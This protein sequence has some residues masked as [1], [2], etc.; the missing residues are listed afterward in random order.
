MIRYEYSLQS[1]PLRI[2]STAMAE[3][4]HRIP[5]SDS[6]GDYIIL[7]VTSNGPSPLDLKLVATEGIAP[8]ITTSAAISPLI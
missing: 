8:Y 4:I 1:Q 2:V 5:R 7:N 6:E 3:H